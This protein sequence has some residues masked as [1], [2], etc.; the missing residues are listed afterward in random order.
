MGLTLLNELRLASHAKVD[1]RLAIPEDPD[2][3]AVDV[4][5]SVPRCCAFPKKTGRAFRMRVESRWL[6]RSVSCTSFAI[7]R[8]RS[9]YTPG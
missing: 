6:A 4:S 7:G 3:T 9:G 1:G 8:R 5:C 2:A